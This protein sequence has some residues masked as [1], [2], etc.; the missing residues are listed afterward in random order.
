MHLHSTLTMDVVLFTCG[1][2]LI[3]KMCPR[4]A[5]RHDWCAMENSGAAD[6]SHMV[7]AWPSTALTPVGAWLALSRSS[8]N[9][10]P[11]GSTSCSGG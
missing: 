4:A 5:R 8:R 11:P 7:V 10:V 9:S 2:G 6:L 1:Q 3:A